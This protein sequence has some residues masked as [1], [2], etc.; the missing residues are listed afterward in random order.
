MHPLHCLFVLMLLQLLRHTCAAARLQ[1][2]P[3]CVGSGRDI[4][5][6][7]R[8]NVCSG[9]IFGVDTVL[10]RSL[11]VSHRPHPTCTVCHTRD[12]NK[13][14]GSLL[15]A[16]GCFGILKQEGEQRVHR[17]SQKGSIMR[18]STTGQSAKHLE[19]SRRIRNTIKEFPAPPNNPIQ[20][21]ADATCF[22]QEHD[23]Q[24]PPLLNTQSAVL[25]L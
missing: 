5:W 17:Y 19:T 3:M 18:K 10:H 2:R 12:H 22:Y 24:A 23:S 21:N 11:T 25:V 4:S 7:R 6:G 14:A 1:F 13:A 8:Y 20:C 15:H 16:D 9:P